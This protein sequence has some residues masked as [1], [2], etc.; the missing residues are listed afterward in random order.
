MSLP[1]D[2]ISFAGDVT[3]NEVTIINT[4][5]F[6]QTIT[7]Q[8]AG[9][10]IYEDLFSPFITGN[11]IVRDGVDFTNLFPMVGDEFVKLRVS[12]P[13]LPDEDT[14]QGEFYIYRVSDRFKTAER[15]VAYILHFMSKEGL[16]DLNK[17]VSRTYS[18]KVSDI[19][20]RIITSNDGLET[21]K[22]FNVEPTINATKYTSN[23]WTPVQNIVYLT[24]TA[25]NQNKSASYVFF[26]TKNGLNFV[27]LDALYQLP[28]KQSFV[29]DNYSSDK[30][31][32][33]GTQRNIEKDYQR[34]VEI[35]TPEVF[36]YIDRIESGMY[37]SRMVNYDLTTKI[38]SS[39]NY[40]AKDKFASSKHVNEYSLISKAHVGRPNAL[41]VREH[42]YYGNFSGYGD[43]T[44]AKIV[45][46]RLSLLKQAEAFKLEIT[47]PGR[48]DYT[49]GQKINL[50]MFK[51]NHIVSEGA[52]IEDEVD[53]MY[54]GNYLIGAI[55]HY[56]TKEKH[57]CRMQLIK[58]SFIVD[59]DKQ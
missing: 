30:M 25:V 18:G 41:I 53:Q 31:P 56:I 37:A 45:Q 47:V 21:I 46:Q 34:I 55:N 5:G 36:N 54:S 7:A 22:P 20:E 13:T 35:S 49:A 9:I 23:F 57:E 15:E 59:L 24:N 33:G 40:I 2:V 32:M 29:W 28:I 58:D 12:T 19:V 42:K 3:I 26:E 48:T 52:N 39:I 11:I 27:T 38:Y 14:Y 4:R 6:A 51:P 10:E 16:I 44:N 50:R 8:V 1:T 43:V 17:K